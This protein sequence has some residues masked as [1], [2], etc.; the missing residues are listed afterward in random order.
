MKSFL[1]VIV[2]F[3][4]TGSLA[5]TKLIYGKITKNDGSRI[6]GT[7]VMRNYEDQLIINSYTGGTDNSAT[8][9]ITVPTFTYVADFR[10]MIKTTR[11][12]TVITKTAA[13]TVKP[14]NLPIAAAPQ[15]T[16]NVQAL[17]TFPIARVEIS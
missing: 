12:A 3:A 1:T 4:V 11:P 16:I 7:S 15:K 6:K 8:I 9:E 14:T 2:L 13:T 10:N 5:Q 17:Q